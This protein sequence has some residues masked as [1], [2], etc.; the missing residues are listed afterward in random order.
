M[1]T[2]YW[3]VLL[4]VL[5]IGCSALSIP[6]LL[7]QQ[8]AS[9]AEIISEGKVLET[10]DLRIE[11]QIPITNSQGGTNTITIRDGKIAV[12]EAS[13]PDHYCMHRGFCNSGAQIVCLPNLLVIRFTEQ[14]EIDMV[15][16]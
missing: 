9:H 8:A 12:T 13:C 15:V 3:A 10:V 11:R 7:P 4:I 14:Q 2:K 16:G 5:L 1:K 6:L